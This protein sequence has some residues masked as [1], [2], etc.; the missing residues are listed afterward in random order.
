MSA[1]K[2]ALPCRGGPAG[3]TNNAG[4]TRR[5]QKKAV[6]ACITVAISGS[7][8]NRITAGKWIREPLTVLSS[9]VIRHGVFSIAGSSGTG[10]SPPGAALVALQ[11]TTATYHPNFVTLA[12]LDHEISKPEVQLQYHNKP[13]GGTGKSPPGAALVALQ[14]TTATYHPNF[15]TLAC[16]DHEISK[17]HKI[18]GFGQDSNPGPHDPTL[19]V[20]GKSRSTMPSLVIQEQE[21]LFTNGPFYCSFRNVMSETRDC[22]RGSYVSDNLCRHPSLFSPSFSGDGAISPAGLAR[23]GTSHVYSGRGRSYTH[24]AKGHARSTVG[25]ADNVLSVLTGGARGGTTQTICGRGRSHTH[26][27]QGQGNFANN[28]EN[29]PHRLRLGR[30]QT[31]RARPSQHPTNNVLVSPRVRSTG[32]ARAGTFLSPSAAG[33]PHTDRAQGHDNT[34]NNLLFRPAEPKAP[35]SLLGQHITG[36]IVQQHHL[37]LWTAKSPG[38]GGTNHTVCDWD[39][40][41]PIA[42]GHDNITAPANTNNNVLIV[43]PCLTTGPCADLRRGTEATCPAE[44][45]QRAAVLYWG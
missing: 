14:T 6:V 37:K 4:Q 38:Q 16:L 22:S 9:A 31:L 29:L 21:T 43:S 40:L 44:G 3:W 25:P 15:V 13:L 12:C 33:D 45:R 1:T 18:G 34:A 28:E 2:I 35:A 23:G 26:R 19:V 10:K 27:A 36:C 7:A 42:Q 32:P 8:V 39:K 24:R 5:V 17:P 30:S 20:M 41:T 11:T